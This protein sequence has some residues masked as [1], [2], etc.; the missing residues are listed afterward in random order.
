[1][2]T[3]REWSEA[4]HD[5]R[6]ADLEHALERSLTVDDPPPSDLA[7]RVLGV[8]RRHTCSTPGCR[9]EAVVFPP[10]ACVE[11]GGLEAEVRP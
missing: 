2:V 6:N 1:M 9:R 8:V 11:H 7:A 5:P 4:F 3:N 10:P